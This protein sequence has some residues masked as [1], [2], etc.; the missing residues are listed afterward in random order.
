MTDE[1]THDDDPFGWPDDRPTPLEAANTITHHVRSLAKRDGLTDGDLQDLGEL[2]AEV[3]EA[4]TELA[5][6]ANMIAAAA[7]EAMT[8]DDEPIAGVGVISRAPGRSTSWDTKGARAAVRAAIVAEV[9][10][11]ERP[12][13]ESIIDQTLDALGGS[14]KVGGLE[15]LG[16]DP[17]AYRAVTATGWKVKLMRVETF[18]PTTTTEDRW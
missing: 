16:L 17:D 13:A 7:A 14:P 18:T 15:R 10:E 1:P 5:A 6:I 12:L 9:T 2:F 3:D 8:S 11:D 4:L